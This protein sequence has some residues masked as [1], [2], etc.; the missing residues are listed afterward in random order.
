MP[1]NQKG[2]AFVF[3][4]LLVEAVTGAILV[5]A[6][7]AGHSTDS[8]MQ[9]LVST[10]LLTVIGVCLSGWVAYRL[11]RRERDDRR[12]MDEGYRVPGPTRPWSWLSRRQWMMLTIGFTVIAALTGTPADLELL[13]GTTTAVAASTPTTSPTAANPLPV[14]PTSTPEAPSPTPPVSP[15]SSAGPSD[16]VGPSGSADPSSEPS[17]VT[18]TPAP[19]ATTYLDSLDQV[20]GYDYAQPVGLNGV[21]Y[22]RS[23]GFSCQRATSNYVQWSVAGYK[24]FSAMAGIPDD[25]SNAFGGIAE[26][27]FYNQD[28]TQLAK[29]F[30]VSLGHPLQVTLQL[31]GAVQL[32]VTCSG[33]DVKTGN[34]REFA[35]ALGNAEILS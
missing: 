20:N 35:G 32:R 22:P 33:R 9:L 24:T 7:L 18:S 27:I 5:I 29:P 26:M 8:A 19:A 31:N 25:A 34:E 17:D 6:Q 11:W 16:T 21:R 14:G 15:S 12:A 10:A 1:G 13:D 30:D 2:A 28:G 4:T 3:L 23:V